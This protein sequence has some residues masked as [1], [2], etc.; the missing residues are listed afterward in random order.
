LLTAA[1]GGRLGYRHLIDP[2]RIRNALVRSVQER[3]SADASIDG[4]EWITPRRLRLSDIRV[5]LPDCGPLRF[6]HPSP[7]DG[8]LTEANPPTMTVRCTSMEVTVDRLAAV[9][10]GIRV[11]TMVLNGVDVAIPT[12]V[13]FSPGATTAVL[14]GRWLDAIGY[15]NLECRD[16]RVRWKDGAPQA[17]DWTDALHLSLFARR[18][19][20]DDRA[21]DLEWTSLRKS[22]VSGAARWFT[23]TGAVDLS[24]GSFPWVAIDDVARALRGALPALGRSGAAVTLPGGVTVEGHAR[25]TR[26][27]VAPDAHGRLNRVS[28]AIE[29]RGVNVSIPVDD[30]ERALGASQRF[31]RLEGLGG[32]LR[33]PALG[34]IDYEL[35]GSFHGSPCSIFGSARADA[36][37]GWRDVKAIGFDGHVDL[38]GMVF[39]DPTDAGMA[40]IVRAFRPVAN[41]YRDYQPSGRF[42]LTASMVKSAGADQPIVAPS[43]RIDAR[44]AAAVCRFFPYPT[45]DLWGTV[46]FTPIGILIDRMTARHGPTSIVVNGWLSGPKWHDACKLTI[47]ATHAVLDR[48]LRNAS[49]PQFQDAFDRF[50]LAGVADLD[51][52]LSRPEAPVGQRGKWQTRL[53]AELVE[54]TASW[55]EFPCRI[56][57]ITGTCTLEGGRI[58]F[59][60]VR[61]RYGDAHVTIGGQVMRT[62]GRLEDV[63]VVV[64]GT[65]VSCDDELLAALPAGPRDALRNLKPSGTFDATCAL[66]FD[67]RR[68]GLESLVQVTPRDLRIHPGLL[69]TPLRCLGG[70]ATVKDGR[71]RLDQIRASLG[72]TRV[73]LNGDADLSGTAGSTHVVAT[74]AEV[75]LSDD[76]L[77]SVIRNGDG[78]WPRWRIETPVS[79]TTTLDVEAGAPPSVTHEVQLTDARVVHDA[80]PYPLDRVNGV[81]TVDGGGARATDIRAA[82]GDARVTLGFRAAPGAAPEAP[83]ATS[84]ALRV[85]GL[86]IDEALL[87]ALPQRARAVLRELRMPQGLDLRIDEL[88]IQPAHEGSACVVSLRGTAEAVDLSIGAGGGVADAHVILSFDAQGSDPGEGYLASG[89]LAV[90]SAR[91]LGHPITDASATWQLTVGS[92]DGPL[93]F[94]IDRLAAR[95]HAGLLEA[96]VEVASQDGRTAYDVRGAARDLDVASYLRT[97]RRA[98]GP[99]LPEDVRGVADALIRVSGPVNDPLSRRGSGNV[100]VRDAYLYRLP[101]LMAI[102]Q[103]FQLRMPDR[104]AFDQLE[105]S[106]LLNGN[107][108]QFEDVRLT[109]A[110]LKLRGK[111]TMTLPGRRLDVYLAAWQDVPVLTKLIELHVT[112]TPTEPHVEAG[113]LRFLKDL[114]DTLSG[115]P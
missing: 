82:F 89:T 14:G 101:L 97:D 96:D 15:P 18:S 70:S 24:S 10:S 74:A 20:T 88:G 3:W 66:S 100:V 51:L 36:S 21:V 45:E 84:A 93:L 29:L 80:L 46:D 44:G 62:A 106:F 108:V 19:A 5:D 69:K 114:V 2:E 32:E 31:I 73:T 12:G 27:H 67:R 107:T 91:L 37:S 58:R 47:E 22:G 94:R 1:V 8:P 39:P 90:P 28:A 54:V 41:L 38:R 72:E 48:A 25:L 109:G 64:A 57:Q 23:D 30:D 42:D 92:G 17:Q 43:V 78:P 87:S 13:H 56:E 4:A 52:V 111:G 9:Y 68:A 85:D 110:A 115:R 104:N 50:Q 83:W 6:A 105:A 79:I 98:A 59:E 81:I 49:P 71:V 11:E 103:V 76:V 102:L 86:R 33:M 35:S 75:R 113:P 99:Q 60:N 61:G 112:G 26:L 63:D 53:R 40:R 65:N 77:E 55:E 95:A 34:R 7:A 16:V